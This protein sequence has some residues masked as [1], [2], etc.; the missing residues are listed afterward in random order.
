[1]IDDVNNKLRNINQI[2][3][4]YDGDVRKLWWKI[5]YNNSQIKC[6]IILQCA[7][8]S[9]NHNVCMLVS[10]CGLEKLRTTPCG[11]SLCLCI[12]I[13]MTGFKKSDF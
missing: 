11:D 3:I 2:I 7:V 4:I 9:I 12:K 6:I 8:A 10:Q 5:V 1:M 13:A